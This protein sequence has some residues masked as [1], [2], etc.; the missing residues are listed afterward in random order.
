MLVYTWDL[1][2]HDQLKKILDLSLTLNG[3]H[4]TIN[5]SNG[6]KLQ[7]GQ[8][9]F[10]PPIKTVTMRTGSL[11]VKFLHDIRDGGGKVNMPDGMVNTLIGELELRLLERETVQKSLENSA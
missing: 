9:K 3:F 2:S 6:H 4:V 1:K 11:W 10:E 7:K 8:E 5:P